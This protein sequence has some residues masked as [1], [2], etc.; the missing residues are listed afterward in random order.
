[1][2]HKKVSYKILSNKK[3]VDCGR[4]LKQ[5]LI[6]KNPDAEK[7]YSCYKPQPKIEETVECKNCEG[8]GDIVNHTKIN[9]R[10]VDVP[11]EICSDCGGSGL[12]NS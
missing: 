10:S 12:V 11:Y 8:A 6:D 3:C 5:N 4:F 7:C 9:C 2:R 1:M